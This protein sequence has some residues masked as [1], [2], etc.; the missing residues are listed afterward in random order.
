MNKKVTTGFTLIEMMIV[1]AIIGI[2]SA[3]AI[4]S[5]SEYIKKGKR[6]DAKVELL[7]MA[8]LQESY[9]VQNLSYA[10]TTI[11]LGFTGTV[12]S[13]QDEYTMTIGSLLPAGCTGVSGPTACTQYTLTAEGYGAQASD[14]CK[15]FTI[16][17]TG[18]KGLSGLTATPEK[19]RSCWK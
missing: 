17:H 15:N 12:K 18:Q 11:Q 4:P 6:A 1:V 3:I 7:R 2:I 10:A 19:I 14:K 13:E 8:Q 5:Y 9:F 16:S